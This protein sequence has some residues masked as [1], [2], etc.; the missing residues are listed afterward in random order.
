[1][2]AVIIRNSFDPE[3]PVYLFEAEEEAVSRLRRLWED[4]VNYEKLLGN[5]VDAYTSADGWYGKITVKYSDHDSVTEY[6]I[7]VVKA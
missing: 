6:N 1:M 3:I 7:G 5:T 4:A 2:Y